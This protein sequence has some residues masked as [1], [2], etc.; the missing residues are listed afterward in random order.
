MRASHDHSHAL[1]RP[2]NRTVAFHGVDPI[3]QAELP[4][5]Q[6]VQVGNT[7]VD[8]SP[9]QWI[10][11]PAVDVSWNQPKQILHGKG[12][13]GPVVRLHFGQRDQQIAGERG[14]WKIELLKL[15]KGALESDARDVVEVQVRK[16]V[17][18]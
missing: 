18:E 17:L 7:L 13:A 14:V 3:Y 9:M 4:W 5:E 10:F 6:V 12:S 16:A 1:A 11:R 15:R 2:Q 8:A